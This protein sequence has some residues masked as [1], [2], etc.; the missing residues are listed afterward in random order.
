[1]KNM[2]D[3]REKNRGKRRK[4][5]KSKVCVFSLKNNLR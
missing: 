3:R 1:M 2:I 4:G 5:R